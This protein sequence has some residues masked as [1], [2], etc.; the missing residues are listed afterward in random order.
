MIVGV[1]RCDHIIDYM[2][3]VLHYPAQ[4]KFRVLRAGNGGIG[5]W[6]SHGRI[7]AMHLGLQVQ[8][9]P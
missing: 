7:L 3:S 4:V 6:R 9:L 1:T 8:T 5:A 2:M